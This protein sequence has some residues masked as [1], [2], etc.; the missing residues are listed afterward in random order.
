M[1]QEVVARIL[2]K[3][4]VTYRA[5]LAPQKGYRNASY[6][7]ETTTEPLNVILYKREPGM[8]ER[9]ARINT[10]GDFLH[11]RGVA[12]RRARDHRILSLSTDEGVQRYAALY[13]YLPGATIPWEAYTMERIKNL[14]KAM[15]DLHAELADYPGEVP[16]IADELLALNN[17]M[18]RYFAKREVAGAMAQKLAVRIKKADF[19]KL[20]A[21][22][23]TQPGQAIHM[24]FVRGNILFDGDEITGII[25]FEKAGLG[26]PALD[27]A[28]TL[29]FLYVDCKYKPPDKT[30]KYFLQSGYHKRGRAEL[31]SVSLI[32]ALVPFFLLH[33]FY[34]F[35]RHNPYEYLSQNEHYRRTKAMLLK[36]GI[37]QRAHVK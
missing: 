24:D 7:I 11:P 34:K 28:R 2:A 6:K 1:E 12:V 3:Y 4:G 5:I 22:C 25:D 9:I 20:L 30:Y 32:R 29:A 19:T 27:I 16:P 13:N 17:R 18:M 31:P 8:Q 26:T 23:A 15:G 10:L 36:H 14:G 33:D 35:L 21:F 37:I